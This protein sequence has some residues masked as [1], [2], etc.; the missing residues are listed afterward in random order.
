MIVN[1][2]HLHIRSLTPPFLACLPHPLVQPALTDVCIVLIL[3]SELNDEK[4]SKK[5]SQIALRWLN[6]NRFPFD[7]LITILEM[8]SENEVRATTDLTL[9]RFDMR[10]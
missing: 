7:H 3:I 8:R 1:S 9:P 10:P 5:C 2:L 4:E 6:D